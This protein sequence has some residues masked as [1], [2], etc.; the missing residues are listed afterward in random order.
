MEAYLV[1][2]TASD[3]EEAEKI[4][5][6]LIESHLAAC[7]NIMDKATSLF[8]WD[9]QVQ[10]EEECVFLAKTSRDRLRGLIKEVERLH[11]YEVPCVVAL[12]ILDGN[13]E[14]IKWIKMETFDP[15][16]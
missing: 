14:F 2:M 15:L 13:P 1:Y 4:G 5:R 7:V 11:S 9:G 10:S 6:A 12:P 16:E 3:K 8:W